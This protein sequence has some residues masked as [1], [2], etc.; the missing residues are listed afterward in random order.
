MQKLRTNPSIIQISLGMGSP[1]LLCGWGEGRGGG[2]GGGGGG[3]T[4]RDRV[5]QNTAQMDQS[6]RF[7][8]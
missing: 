2:W 6:K 4:Q 5:M 3:Q 1:C 8:N 7:G